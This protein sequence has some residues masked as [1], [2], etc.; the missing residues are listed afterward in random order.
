MGGTLP[1]LEAP[2]TS[3]PLGFAIPL[4]ATLDVEGLPQS[5]TG[6]TALLTGENAA[7]LHGR[8][9]GPWVPVALRPLVEHRSV[10]Q[11]ALEGGRSA[12][13]ANAYPR[14]WP[15]SGRRSRFIAAPPLAA[16]AAGL[17]DRHEEA[18]GEGR[19][20]SSEIVN[21]GWRRHLGHDWLPEV[22][23]QE[24]GANL[25]A[26]SSE[27]DL[28]LFAHY[29]TDDAGHEQSMDAAVS[30]LTRVDGFFEGLLQEMTSDTLLLVVS[31]HGN[32]EDARAGHTRN[33]VLGIVSGPGA[34]RARELTDL[35]HVTP[36][37]LDCLAVDT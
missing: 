20:V 19:A 11:R 25:A 30:A 18:L 5:G 14:G 1:T 17:M 16:K 32:I 34:D 10:L 24:A 31:D 28:T 37:I 22:S 8:H 33:P 13:F 12:A 15:G 35:R 29:A 9:F 23:P 4:D 26:I 3:G 36:F 21:D 7:D 2:R 6:Q 27:V